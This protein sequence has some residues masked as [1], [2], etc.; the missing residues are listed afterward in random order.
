MTESGG[1]GAYNAAVASSVSTMRASGTNATARLTFAVV[2][3]YNTVGIA[4][5]EWSTY[6]IAAVQW[7]VFVVGS[8]GNILV[9][10]VLVWRRS[11]SQVRM[12]F[13]YCS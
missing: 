6:V 10:V 13:Y 4:E 12:K 9:L 7:L 11:R 3:Q 2:C 1:G 5:Y 8:V